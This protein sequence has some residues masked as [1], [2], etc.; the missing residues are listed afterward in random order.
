MEA[1]LEFGSSAFFIALLQIVWIDLLLSGDNSIVIALACRNLPAHQRRKGI[2]WGVT[3]AIVLRVILT[4]FAVSLL[5]IPFLKILGGVLLLYIGIKLVLPQED[6]DGHDIEAKD[7]LMAAIKTIVIADFAMSLDNVIGVA[8]AAKGH[9]GLLIFGLALSIPLVV[10]GS[11]IVLSLMQ[12][13]PWIV[14]A[15]GGLLGYLAGE[16]IQTDPVAVPF[17][18]SLGVQ[19]HL[20]AWVG[21]VV[22]IGI[23]KFLTWRMASK[24]G[25]A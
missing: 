13:F 5:Q 24:P 14:V 1:S 3:A 20:L 6:E 7:K 21:V 12:R 8:G 15:G 4:A 16:M 17:W 23:G 25:A 11:K 18:T 10:W 22:V 9:F 2:F 19:G